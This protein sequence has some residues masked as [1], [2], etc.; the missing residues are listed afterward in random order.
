MQLITDLRT[1]SLKR[2][3]EL[4]QAVCEVAGL[5]QGKLSRAA[6]AEYEQLRRSGAIREEDHVGSLGQP[7]ISRVIAGLQDPTYFQVFIWLQVIQAR[8]TSKQF[9]HRCQA[10]GIPAPQ[11]S[12]ELE[13]TLWKL[14]G[15]VP[16]DELARVYEQSQNEKPLDTNTSLVEHKEVRMKR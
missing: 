9:A 11:F 3:G 1:T 16:P 7:V 5:T 14:A 4:L 8:Y 12:A 15:F 10:L 13:R 2:F 6:T